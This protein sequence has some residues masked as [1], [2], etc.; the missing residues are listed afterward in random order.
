[1]SDLLI[2]RKRATEACEVED[3]AYN[4]ACVYAMTKQ[5]DKMLF[6]LRQLLKQN[7]WRH[8]I[9]A[10]EHYFGNY[11]DDPDFRELIGL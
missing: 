3:T 11:W 9:R 6:H 10:K 4:L 8:I 2:A 7:R 1:M 5:K